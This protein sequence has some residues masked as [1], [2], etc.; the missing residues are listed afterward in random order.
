MISP[1]TG[2]NPAGFYPETL[3]LLL[4][5]PTVLPLD[6][7]DTDYGRTAAHWA[8]F[9]KAHDLLLQLMLAGQSLSVCVCLTI[10]LML[11]S[12]VLCVKN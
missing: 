4:Q 10:R 6:T 9:Y 7:V 8:V 12:Y 3:Q 11:F 5:S 1:A 2:V